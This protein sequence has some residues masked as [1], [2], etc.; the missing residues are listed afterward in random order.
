M[1]KSWVLA[2][3][4]VFGL[5]SA[6]MADQV[7]NADVIVQGKGCIGAE[8]AEDENFSFSTLK[9]KAESPVIHMDDTSNSASFPANDWRVGI[10]DDTVGS[11]ASFY[12][13]DVTGDRRVLEISPAGDV[14]LGSQSV[15]VSGAVSVGSDLGSRRVA[16]V[17]DPEA[18]TDAVNLRTAEAMIDADVT[19]DDK[20]LV[21]EAVAAINARLTRL[22]DRISAL[23]AQ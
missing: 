4:L 18:G 7:F 20:A 5:S 16:Y 13:E 12:I 1:K 11:E 3:G 2:S 19:A 22:A 10:S 14:A 15:I 8:C 6:A 17:A 21:D 23:E 9:I